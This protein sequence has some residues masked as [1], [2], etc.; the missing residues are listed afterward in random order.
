LG[1]GDSDNYEFKHVALA[2]IR[3]APA[4]RG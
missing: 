3:E 2:G 4:V 1:R